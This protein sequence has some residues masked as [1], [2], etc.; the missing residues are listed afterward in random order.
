MRGIDISNW[1]KGIDVTG[2]QA[3]FVIVK[4]TEGNYFISPDFERQANQVLQCGKLLGLYHYANGGDAIQEAKFFLEKSKNYIGKA[5]L[6]LDWEAGSNPKFGVNDL[7]W[8]KQFCEYVKSSVGITPF[9]YVQ[10][11][12]MSRVVTGYPLWVAQYADMNPTGFQDNPWN[13]GAYTCAIRQYASTG[14]ISG[15]NGDLDLN[16]AYIDK[17][18]WLSYA[19]ASVNS[20]KPNNPTSPTMELVLDVLLGRYGDGEVRK[21]L[22][23]TRY[24]EVQS[25][26]NHIATASVQ[27]LAGEVIAGKY[28]SG[29][30]RKK[31]LGTRYDVVQKEVNA[32][33]NQ[34]SKVYYTVKNGDNLSNIA[35]VYG[36]T[37]NSIVNLNGLANPNLIYPG[38]R[39]RVK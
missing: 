23:G 19:G 38:Q 15:Y 30:T 32:K 34:S 5:I 8:T 17:S 37:V 10:Q 13:E 16:K 26:I 21:N 27:V 1:Q 6:C 22:L 25:I 11:S 12:A 9:I 33:L 39:L 35:S 4:A 7:E 29:E 3:D 36:V 31:L 28:G 14:R 20:G 24:N 2:I 18:K